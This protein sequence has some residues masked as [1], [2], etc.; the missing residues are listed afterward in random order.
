MNLTR[1]ITLSAVAALLL[2][3][4]ACSGA[5][6]GAD[7]QGASSSTELDSPAPG[8]SRVV[9][10]GDSVAAGQAVP[11]SAAFD[12]ADVEFH[13]MAT[14]GGGSLV[15]PVAESTWEELPE[16]I[17]TAKPSTVV[18]QVTTYDWGT[19]DEQRAAYQRLVDEAEKV[20]A[21]TAFVTMPPIVADDF[22]ADHM[23]ELAQTTSVAQ[24]VADASD[25]SAVLLDAS[26]VWGPDYEQLR[27]G[28]ADRSSD[29]IHTCPQG[30]ARFASWLLDELADVY[31]GFTPPAP[32]TW[33]NT[34]WADSEDFVGC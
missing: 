2:L 32:T 25:G 30:A 21:T 17:A 3:T 13:S 19:A 10:L 9:F 5:P 33:A 16:R 15:G 28:V 23:G 29:G 22:Y 6:S 24:R 18:Y 27:D 20:G 4:T 1:T 14:V 12:A 11:L 26:A 31:P 8:L 7:P 34:G